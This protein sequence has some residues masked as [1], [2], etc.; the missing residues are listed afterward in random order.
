MVDD[1]YF[2]RYTVSGVTTRPEIGD[3]YQ[4]ANQTKG[5]IINIDKTNGIIEFRTIENK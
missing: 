5:E 3:V 4:V 2:W 1:D